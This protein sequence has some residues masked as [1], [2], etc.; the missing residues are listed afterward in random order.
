VVLQLASS[1]RLYTGTVI[2]VIETKLIVDFDNLLKY[3]QIEN[4]SSKISFD[5][6]CTE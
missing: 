2:P 4:V 1:T 3:S 6:L 5:E